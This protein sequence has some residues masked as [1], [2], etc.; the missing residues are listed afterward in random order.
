M[1]LRSEAILIFYIVYL[2]FILFN[3]GLK[4][5]MLLQYVHNPYICMREEEIMFTPESTRPRNM[6][7]ISGDYCI[8]GNLSSQ[9]V[10]VSLI[11]PLAKVSPLES[12]PHSPRSGE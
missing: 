8:R 9:N 3:V 10:K 7:E 2:L 1:Y 5:S 4:Q 6:F 11:I 12:N